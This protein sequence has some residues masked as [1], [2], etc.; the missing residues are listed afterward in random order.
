MLLFYRDEYDF[1]TAT[2]VGVRYRE[3]GAVSA[4]FDVRIHDHPFRARGS[5]IVRFGF[6]VEELVERRDGVTVVV[7]AGGDLEDEVVPESR[8]VMVV[9]MREEDLVRVLR[10]RDRVELGVWHFEEVVAVTVVMVVLLFLLIFCRTVIGICCSNR[11]R[12]SP[13]RLALVENGCVNARSRRPKKL[14]HF[15]I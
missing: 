12:F 1:D 6:D 11:E 4:S 5:L 8:G 10:D 3:I 9:V 15:L 13:L 7:Y 2:V 14:H